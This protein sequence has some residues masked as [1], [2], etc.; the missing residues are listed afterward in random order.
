MNFTFVTDLE[1]K[2]KTYKFRLTFNP[3]NEKYVVPARL[4]E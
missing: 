3:T 4:M 1:E 2:K